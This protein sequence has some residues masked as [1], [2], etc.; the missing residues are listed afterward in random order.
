M[1]H[2]STPLR[3][4]LAP[5]CRSPRR[6]VNRRAFLRARRAS[7]SGC[8][9]SR[10]CPNVRPGQPPIRRCSA[11]SSWRP[12]AWSGR[13]FFPSAT[14]A[15]THGLAGCHDRQGDQRACAARSRTCCSS[16]D[17]NFPMPG[18]TSCGHA[19]G[20]CQSLTAAPLGRQCA[21][22]YSTG[23][24]ADMVIAKAVNA[25]AADPLTLYAGNAR[26]AT[27]PSGSRSRAPAQVRFGQPT[28]TRTRSTPSSSG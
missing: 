8:R 10:G 20:L 18:P 9:F 25:S 17:I 13:S 15:L 22:A 24:S 14:G 3:K 1:S 16:R 11:C 7:P 6:N 5:P 28:T 4:R 23:I 27:S 2:R 26:T 21:T 19:Q 12:A